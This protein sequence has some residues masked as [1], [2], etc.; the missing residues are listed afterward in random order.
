MSVYIGPCCYGTPEPDSG[1]RFITADSDTGT[2]SNKTLDMKQNRIINLAD[3]TN[4]QDAT[5]LRYLTKVASNKVNKSGDTMSGDLSMGQNKI[6]NIKSPEHD[7]DAVSMEFVND[8]INKHWH[9][10][11]LKSIG[12]YIVFPNGDGSKTYFSVR[13]K[14][15]VKLDGAGSGI[16]FKLYFD[17]VLNQITLDHDP[18][19]IR[20]QNFEGLTANQQLGTL[21][22]P[23]VFGVVFRT[24]QYQSWT[25][26]FSAKLGD[27][28]SNR[29]T[30]SML[31]FNQRKAVKFDWDNDSFTYSITSRGNVIPLKTKT[32]SVNT[33]K[34]NHFTFRYVNN[35]LEFFL[36][37]EKLKE[38]N[39]DLDQIGDMYF[40]VQEIGIITF[41]DRSLSKLEIAEHFMDFHVSKFSDDDKL[42]I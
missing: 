10:I 4:L 40:G 29:K 42:L 14:K 30:G 36:N 2:K 32:V 15:N 38:F 28:S 3:P 6:T 39:A 31:G 35:K 27:V 33:K 18:L 26:C 1:E 23:N 19:T 22:N 11:E 12:R 25:L 41:Y 8:E 16:T 37:G 5:S 20:V 7:S 13:G 34:M 24:L 17:E 9:R 21:S